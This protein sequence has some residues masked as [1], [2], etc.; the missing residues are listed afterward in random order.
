MTFLHI[1][2]CQPDRSGCTLALQL[3]LGVST[4]KILETFGRQKVTE[5]AKSLF[6]GEISTIFSES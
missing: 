6:F 3:Q 1:K 5:L 4:H 2:S